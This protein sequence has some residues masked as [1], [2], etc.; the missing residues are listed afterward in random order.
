MPI[1]ARQLFEKY[2]SD[3]VNHNE[4]NKQNEQKALQAVEV[5]VNSLTKNQG[6]AFNAVLAA[7]RGVSSDKCI[8]L[9]GPGSSGKSYLHNTI[10]STLNS[11]NIIVLP[12]AWTGIAAN[13]S[14]G[15]RTAHSTFKLPFLLNEQSTFIIWDEITMA[16]KYALEAVD[17]MLR[18][19]CCCNELFGGKVVIVSGNFRQTLPAV[20]RV[21]RTQILEACVKRSSSWCHFVVI[22]PTD[23][24]SKGNIVQGIFGESIDP[25]DLSTFSE[26]ILAPTNT[27]VI[28]ID[29]EILSKIKGSSV[30]YLSVDR[31]PSYAIISQ[32][33][34]LKR[35]K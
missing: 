14:K 13:L 33:G 11:E 12:V 31:A 19:V 5:S 3:F 34:S 25:Q 30:D 9:D 23:I 2:K 32:A 18:D 26:V 10:I 4:Y 29:N 8:Y 15:G 20:R 1:N 6:V 21:N 24:L 7:V 22:I 17:R 35:L 28:A 27:D 16:S